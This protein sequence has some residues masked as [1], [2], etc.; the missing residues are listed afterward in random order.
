LAVKADAQERAHAIIPVMRDLQEEGFDTL[1][2]LAAE[3]NTRH[4]VT[5]RGGKRHARSVRNILAP[6]ARP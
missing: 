6:A 3:L 5:P 1:R 4:V 2:A